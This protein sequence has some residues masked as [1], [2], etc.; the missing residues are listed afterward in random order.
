[1]TAVVFR[2][3]ILAADTGVWG[4]SG[5]VV[6]GHRQKIVEVAPGWHFAGAGKMA[7][8]ILVEWCLK[9]FVPSRHNDVAKMADLDQIDVKVED[10]FVGLLASE[11]GVWRLE[12][13]VRVYRV[14]MPW[15]AI[16][17]PADFLHG[18]LAAGATA[19]R[20]VELAIRHTDGAAGHVIWRK[21]SP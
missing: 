11:A 3:G 5:A 15:H 4:V 2:D 12:P 1:M 10:E 21:I 16:G 19:E 8:L 9:T 13:G 18:A 20:A 14:E 7:D 17:A 6:V